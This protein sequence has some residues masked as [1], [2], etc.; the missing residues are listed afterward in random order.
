MP[1]T[2]QELSLLINPLVPESVQH[3]NRVLS[4]LHSLTS[5]LLGLTAGILAL[6]SA[7][8]FAFYL[9]GTVLVSGLFHLLVLRRSGGKGAGVFFPGAGGEI[10]G[11]DER[12]LVKGNG[13]RRGAW[14]DVW[15][16]G[17]VLGEALSGFILGWAG[18]GGVLR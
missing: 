7:T 16:G 1:A 9:L 6:Q 11:I 17:G 13:G 10:A 5:F 15:L 18:V 12:G 2:K 3:N 14:R 8:G 4:Q